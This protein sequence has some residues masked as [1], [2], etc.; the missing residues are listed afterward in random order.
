MVGK[1]LPLIPFTPSHQDDLPSTACWETVAAF[2]AAL[3]VARRRIA[4]WR[5]SGAPTNLDPALWRAWFARCGKR[6]F[7]ARLDAALPGPGLAPAG[8]T[9]V[10]VPEAPAAQPLRDPAMSMPALPEDATAA[11]LERHWRAV[12]AQRQAELAGLEIARLRREVVPL[13][14]VRAAFQ[15]LVSACLAATADR[16]W[17]AL[18]PELDA[19]DNGLR[20]RL[21]ARHDHAVAQLR[22]QLQLDL[23]AALAA[24]IKDTP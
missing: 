11:D 15:A 3:G 12:R 10:P 17:L 21:R 6:K 20:R 19:I 16:V 7:V 24:V 23:R 18:L 22:E 4:K 9:A 2:A 5:E 13:E 1:S 14:Q 8:P